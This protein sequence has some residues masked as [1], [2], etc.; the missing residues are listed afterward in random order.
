M[1]QWNEIKMKKI[2][3]NNLFQDSLASTMVT[4]LN[5]GSNVAAPT[6]K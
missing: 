3:G 5:N 4:Y 1:N 2:G 6:S